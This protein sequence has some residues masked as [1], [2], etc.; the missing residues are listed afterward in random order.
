MSGLPGP[1]AGEDGAI[2]EGWLRLCRSAALVESGEAALFDL[3]LAPGARQARR[4]FAV[5]F[6][7]RA[8]A[9]V[10]RCAHVAVALDWVPGQVFDPD[11]RVLLCS[12]HGAEYDPASGHCLSGPCRGRGHLEGLAAVERDGW[13][14]VL[15][16]PGPGSQTPGKGPPATLGF[17]DDD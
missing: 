4:G 1:R 14:W 15:V 10:N 5:R 11:G 13:V 9:Y 7:G 6:E 2:V 16:Q 12:V 3:P 8:R 17:S